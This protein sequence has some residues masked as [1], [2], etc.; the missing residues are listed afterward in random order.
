MFPLLP[1]WFTTALRV[2]PRRGTSVHFPDGSRRDYPPLSTPS[3]S[4]PL[5]E[6]ALLESLNKAVF[7]HRFINMK[8]SGIGVSMYAP[9]ETHFF[10]QLYYLATSRRISGRLL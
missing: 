10:W 2:R 3:E 4:L 9:P 7:E 6:H 1:R 8:P 5:H